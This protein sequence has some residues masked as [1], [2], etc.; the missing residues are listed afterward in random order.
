MKAISERKNNKS[1]F[2]A[3]RVLDGESMEDLRESEP[4]FCLVHHKQ[5]EYFASAVKRDRLR[6]RKRGFAELTVTNGGHG[7]NLLRDWLVAN[8]GK[9][10]EFKK[11]QLFVTAVPNSGKTTLMKMLSEYVNIYWVPMFEDFDDEYENDVYDLIVLD[12]FK[13]QRK[14][15]WMNM[16]SQGGPMHLRRKGS[17]YLKTDNPPVIV[18]SNHHLEEC[19][20]KVPQIA[21]EAFRARFDFIMLE[22]D[23]K[24]D[25]FV[26]KFVKMTCVAKE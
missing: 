6:N 10:R 23:Y 11:K 16:F 1:T 25:A 19:Y 5:I 22:Q 18:L 14:L 9:Q 12:E 21:L 13:G 20:S 17:Q 4:G 2:L 8:V 26:P 3:R 15:T 24:D 7:A